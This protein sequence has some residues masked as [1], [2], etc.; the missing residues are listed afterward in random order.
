MIYQRIACLSTET[1][2]TLYLLGAEDCIAGISGF[3]TRPPRARREKPKISG[4]SSAQI[5]RILA[6]RPD[7]VLAYSDLQAGMVG[8]LVRAGVEVHVFNQHDLAGILRMVR[9]LG[10]L[11]DRRDTAE[12]LALE[13]Q[14]LIDTARAVSR[15]GAGARR[16]RVYF[17]EWN[18]PMISGI[19]WVSEL[20]EAAGGE[21]CFGDESHQRLA[22]GRI[23]ADPTEVIRRVPDI[24][25]G[26]W[27]GRKFQA[28]QVRARAGWDAVPDVRDGFL[29]E[30]KSADILSP[31]PCAVTDGLAQMRTIFERWS[32]VNANRAGD[33]GGVGLSP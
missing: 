19:R 7:L 26:S 31:G 13:L 29:C 2:E 10:T 1:V 9:T 30:I 27:C 22:R 5:D 20:I 11:V 8:D 21:D 3:T 33:G 23:I 4:F 15:N 16:P 6:V 25:I 28:A 32:A 24:I 18:D 14:A 17:E 12:A